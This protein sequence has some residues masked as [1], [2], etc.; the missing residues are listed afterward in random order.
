MNCLHTAR[1][2]RL[3]KVASLTT[4]VFFACALLAQ[5]VA[6]QQTKPDAPSAAASPAAPRELTL[7]VTV[8]DIKGHYIRG[9][10]KEHFTVFDGDSQREITKF[11]IGEAPASVGVLFDVSRSTWDRSNMLTAA[12]RAFVRFVRN[13]SP[14]NEYFLWAFNERAIE[15]TGWTQDVAVI[16]EGLNKSA[17]TNL[18]TKGASGTAI[19]DTCAEALDKLAGGSRRKRVL[20]IFT[21]TNADNASR[22]VKFKNVKLRARASEVLIYP[23]VV[24]E[25][26]INAPLDIQ[27]ASELDE[28]ATNTGGKAFIVMTVAQMSDSVDRIATELSQQYMISFVPTNAAKKGE[29][30]KLKIKLKQPPTIKGALFVRT[31]DAYFSVPE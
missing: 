6:A 28:L 21:D 7:A 22:Q 13:A 9:L 16:N 17:L 2:S 23:V 14:R 25:P 20:L 24:T 30:N 12:R 11:E 29:L 1:A 19:Y 10:G 8:T 4:L 26:W 18:P 15:L 3:L 31:R 5:A 27:G